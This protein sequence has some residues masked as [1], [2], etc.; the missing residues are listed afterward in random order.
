[1]KRFSKI[2]VCSLIASLLWGTVAFAAENAISNVL[3]ARVNVKEI[4][5]EDMLLSLSGTIKGD[6]S[7]LKDLTENGVRVDAEKDE[8]IETKLNVKLSESY[9][10]GKD[11]PRVENVQM[12]IEVSKDG[13]IKEKDFTIEYKGKEIKCEK[14]KGKDSYIAYIDPDKGFDVVGDDTVSREFNIIF[15]NEAE[16]DLVFY[17]VFAN[18]KTD[19]NDEI[20]EL[21][22]E[23]VDLIK[24]LPDFT[25][26]NRKELMAK[27]RQIYNAINNLS[28]EYRDILDRIMRDNDI[29]FKDIYD[30]VLKMNS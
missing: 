13:K 4:V 2:V 20:P 23:I 27:V 10:E 3:R 15:N 16:Y 29:N 5:Y 18:D 7:E 28:Q 12:A 14:I 21:V 25:F 19:S 22:Q 24:D 8:I 11:D 30:K 1:M 6:K 26:E 9:K 17:A